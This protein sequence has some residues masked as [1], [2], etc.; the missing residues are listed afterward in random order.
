[1]AARSA[2]A[3][4]ILYDADCGM[5]RV[6][7]AGLLRCETDF[8]AVALQSE[9]AKRLLAHMSEEERMASFHVV[10]ADGEVRSA[11]AAL[12][13]VLD[14]LPGARPLAGL[15][16]R[17]PGATSRFYRLVA[18]NRTRIGPLIPDRIRR[19]AQR[20]LDD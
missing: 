10:L 14:A 1:V 13:E 16:R 19:W 15:S 20:E 12:T 7:M 18:G 4:L 6:V 5:C 11:G 3:V 8:E 17:T 2:S 9:R